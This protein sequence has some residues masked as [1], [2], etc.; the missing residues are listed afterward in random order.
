M[1]K[2]ILTTLA[3]PTTETA[4]NDD[5]KVS[6]A[7]SS[8]KSSSA[9]SQKETTMEKLSRELGMAFKIISNDEYTRLSAG[10]HQPPEGQ[11]LISNDEYVR[12]T[13][14]DGWLWSFIK[15]PQLAIFLLGLAG[16]VAMNAF[17]NSMDVKIDKRIMLLTHQQ[18]LSN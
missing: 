12:L 18:P 17:N 6:V 9:R 1:D 8:I 14:K 2:V 10:C 11:K 5:I 15:S 3:K 7:D 16:T 13:K 4:V